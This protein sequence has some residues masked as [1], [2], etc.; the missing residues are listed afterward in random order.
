MADTATIP[1]SRACQRVTPMADSGRAEVEAACRQHGSLRFNPSALQMIALGLTLG[2]KR[3][4][5]NSRLLTNLAKPPRHDPTLP[6]LEHP[7]AGLPLR[8]EAVLG[9]RSCR[10]LSKRCLISI[11]PL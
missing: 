4:R 1:I 10:G 2:R 8:S 5:L 6:T 11:G 7:P 3:C 9:S